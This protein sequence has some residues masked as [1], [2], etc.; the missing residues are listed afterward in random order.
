MSEQGK[1]QDHLQKQQNITL[2]YLHTKEEKIQV[3]KKL[4]IRQSF[5]F[6][7]CLK[8]FSTLCDLSDQI[9]QKLTASI[10]ST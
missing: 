1:K 6:Q 9:L 2:A 8:S 10:K 3:G 4:K 7:I 5:F